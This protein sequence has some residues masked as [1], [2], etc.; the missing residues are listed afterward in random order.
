MRW[1]KR[2]LSRGSMQQRAQGAEE[3]RGL[4]CRSRTSAAEPAKFP[5]SQSR[6]GTT[7]RV[8]YAPRTHCCSLC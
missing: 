7:A 6:C 3:S 2:M 5:E 4:L 1:E 8:L